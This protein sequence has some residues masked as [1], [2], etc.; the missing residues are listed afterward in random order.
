MLLL[1][2]GAEGKASRSR[3]VSRTTRTYTSRYVAPR[4]NSYTNIYVAP[5]YYNYGYNNY[6]YNY[7]YYIPHSTVVVAGGGGGGGLGAFCLIC[8]V[9]MCIFVF[10][11]A[12]QNGTRDLE[13]D[14]YERGDVVECT[15]VEVVQTTY[16]DDGY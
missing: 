10:L 6:G 1:L 5:S 16:D 14:Y 7:N 15:T 4:S 3:S 12:L 9:V 11:T 8:C 2:M 13:N